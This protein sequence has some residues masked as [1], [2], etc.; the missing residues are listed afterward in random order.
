MKKRPGTKA[1][2]T[3]DLPAGWRRK[4]IKL[5]KQGMTEQQIRREFALSNRLWY[6]LLKREPRF[7]ETIETARSLRMS[8]RLGVAV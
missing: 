6:G 5:A 3:A 8:Q 1:K 4:I 2:T 7:R